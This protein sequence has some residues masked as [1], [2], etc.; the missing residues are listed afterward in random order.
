ML[1]CI[2][3][4]GVSGGIRTAAAGALATQAVLALATDEQRALK[5][6]PEAAT[7]D[8][9]MLPGIAP[10]PGGPQATHSADR[11]QRSQDLPLSRRVQ[12]ACARAPPRH[13]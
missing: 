2:L 1:V 3:A 8:P 12:C 10:R 7:D 11:V 13:G 4:M 6:A 9:P 5:A